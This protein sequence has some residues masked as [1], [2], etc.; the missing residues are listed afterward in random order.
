MKT[1]QKQ[2]HLARRVICPVT[3]ESLLFFY[4]EPVELRFII[5]LKNANGG[6][7]PEGWGAA[8]DD[9]SAPSVPGDGLSDLNWCF[10]ELAA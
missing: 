8:Q 3:Q 10:S 9:I 4:E 7:M 2:I 5:G 1:T 6:V